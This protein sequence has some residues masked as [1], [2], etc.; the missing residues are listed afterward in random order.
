MELMKYKESL[1]EVC[2]SEE[3]AIK[4]ECGCYYKLEGWISDFNRMEVNYAKRIF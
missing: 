3:E 4:E 1:L 2:M